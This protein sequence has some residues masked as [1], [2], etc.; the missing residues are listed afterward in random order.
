M[1]MVATLAVRIKVKKY[2][3]Y[4]TVF[5]F[6]CL[7]LGWRY[8]QVTLSNCTWVQCASRSLTEKQT[9]K[10]QLL[11]DNKLVAIVR[12]QHCELILLP[13]F[14]SSSGSVR[15]TCFL[16]AERIYAR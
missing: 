6:G 9:A 14:E 5:V 16:M 8:V 13:D 10:L 7:P 11:S 15:M 12:L 3:T 2:L 1:H 4:L